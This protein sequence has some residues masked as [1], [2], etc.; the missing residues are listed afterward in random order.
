MG[1]KHTALSV[2][3]NNTKLERI[4]DYPV[5]LNKKSLN[6]FCNLLLYLSITYSGQAD[7]LRIMRLAIKQDIH[8][9]TI[10][11]KRKRVKNDLGFE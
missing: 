7:L 5:P 1:F 9:Q 3:P 4:R 10:N 2:Q 8:V 6:Y 11:G